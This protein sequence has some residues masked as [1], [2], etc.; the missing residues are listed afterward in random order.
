M[1]IIKLLLTIANMPSIAVSLIS[2]KFTE[3]G[4]ELSLAG[5]FLMLPF[6]LVIYYA[7]WS[8]GFTAGE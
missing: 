5:L 3:N 8:L 7:L 1:F 6:S 2:D 4:K